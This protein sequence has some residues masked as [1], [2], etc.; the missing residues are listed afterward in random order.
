MLLRTLATRLLGEDYK[1]RLKPENLPMDK[2]LGHASTLNRAIGLLPKRSLAILGCEGDDERAL[3]ELDAA[4]LAA[5]R[6]G[7]KDL[8][9][10]PGER[11][12][13]TRYHVSFKL[14]KLLASGAW[15]DTMETAAP[16]TDVLG[17]YDAV[18]KALAPHCLVMAHFSHAYHE[19][20]SIYFTL[21][22]HAPTTE[23]KVAL[24]ERAWDAV[25]KAA[26]G[27]GATITHHHGVGL[28]KRD[29]MGLEQGDSR[30]LYDAAKEAL[31]PAGVLNPGK[32]FPPKGSLPGPPLGPPASR[33][34]DVGR[35]ED[36][37][38]EAS[39]DWRG[40]DLAAELHLRGHWLPPLGRT[41]L[42]RT[43]SDWL[44]SG[45]WAAHVGVHTA[46]EHPLQRVAGRLPDGRA[47]R[48]G[49]LPR[50]AA[51]PGPGGAESP[52]RSRSRAT[53][54]PRRSD[55]GWCRGPKLQRHASPCATA[56]RWTATPRPVPAL[57]QRLP[58]V[59][60]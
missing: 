45:S 33:H 23:A 15:A 50:S 7:G 36:G 29:A 6:L 46:W 39:T 8:G 40:A 14:P 2:L 9:A 28:L 3:A 16:W 13:R 38:A 59:F 51:G 58:T 25:L 11:W 52:T 18:R 24:Y 26:H 5:G 32:L 1:D 55:V 30:A 44:E 20:C 12:F 43:V 19:G 10:G 42:E 41:F 53:N 47:W 60:Q 54:Q 4:V 27:A 35:H 34:L 57:V 21:A 56:Q 37:V 31:D 17:L 49:R 48:S 22:G